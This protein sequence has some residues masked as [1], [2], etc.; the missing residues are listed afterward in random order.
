MVPVQNVL[1]LKQ[2]LR[3]GEYEEHIETKQRHLI[4]IDVLHREEYQKEKK[5]EKGQDGTSLILLGNI[6]MQAPG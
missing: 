1:N 3:P 2:S 6:Y 5:E 4:N